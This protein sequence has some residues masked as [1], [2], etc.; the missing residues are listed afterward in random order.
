MPP[1]L[2]VTAVIVG[3]PAPDVFVTEV[4]LPDTRLSFA[5]FRVMVSR[6]VVVPSAATLVG[7]PLNVDVLADEVPAVKV[8]VAV[9]VTVTLSVVSTA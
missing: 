1:L 3:V 5:S 8:T 4:F 2:Q 6:L 9:C 7:L